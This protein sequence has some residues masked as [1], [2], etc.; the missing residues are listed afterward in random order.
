MLIIITNN[1]TILLCRLD[2]YLYITVIMLYVPNYVC[3][4]GI[5]RY[6]RYIIGIESNRY[7]VHA[8]DHIILCAAKQ[9]S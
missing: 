7:T 8:F 1:Y 9:C 3:I 6:N 5:E 4:I 2:M